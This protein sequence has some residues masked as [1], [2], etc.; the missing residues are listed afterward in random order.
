MRANHNRPFVSFPAVAT[1]RP[2][3]ENTALLS[4]SGDGSACKSR[5]VETDQMSAPAGPAVT[6]SSPFGENETS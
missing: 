3:G 6:S 1:Y 2:S 4:P 5:P